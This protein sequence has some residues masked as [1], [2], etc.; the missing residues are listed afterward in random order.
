LS[1]RGGRA[2][3]C[4]RGAVRGSAQTAMCRC[5]S[6]HIDPNSAGLTD[7]SCH[8]AIEPAGGPPDWMDDALCR[9]HPEITWFPHDAQAAT[10]ARAICARC[11]VGGECLRYAL[12]HHIAPGI[13][14]GTSGG[15][16]SRLGQADG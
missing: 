12:D 14:A 7:G 2:H 1:E 3:S 11:Q 9:R 8:L 16:R 6:V 13:W 5:N 10:S 4:G 15:Q